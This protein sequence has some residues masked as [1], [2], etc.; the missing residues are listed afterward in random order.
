MQWSYEAD[1]RVGSWT[2]SW[3]KTDGFALESDDQS[4]ESLPLKLRPKDCESCP[5][6]LMVRKQPVRLHSCEYL[7]LEKSTSVSSFWM[8]G[9]LA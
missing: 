7:E 4:K 6:H 3:N 8:Y 9:M 5:Y 1:P 2:Q